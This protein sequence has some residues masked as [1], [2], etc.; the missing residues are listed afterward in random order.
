MDPIVLALSKY[1][2]GDQV[3]PAVIVGALLYLFGIQQEHGFITF[4]DLFYCF[5]N[6]DDASTSLMHHDRDIQQ[7]IFGKEFYMALIYEGALQ[8]K[9]SVVGSLCLQLSTDIVEN[10]PN[11]DTNYSLKYHQHSPFFSMI[12]WMKVLQRFI[13][14]L[15]ARTPRGIEHELIKRFHRDFIQ[16]TTPDNIV[17]SP[18]Q[19]AERK[20]FVGN[21]Q[22]SE[23]N[24]NADFIQSQESF[25]LVAMLGNKG[26]FDAEKSEPIVRL[27]A[28]IRKYGMDIL[29]PQRL[30]D[31]VISIS[32]VIIS[33]SPFILMIIT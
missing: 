16:Y 13:L 28:Q 26:N 31:Q 19:S 25:N 30:Q 17:K 18:E 22:S 10:Q 29:F 21:K 9:V 23:I 14:A 15:S 24:R 32:S 11:H 12:V 7:N 1:T 4:D 6:F 8:T 20:F 2:H 27:L 5:E 3:A 33:Q